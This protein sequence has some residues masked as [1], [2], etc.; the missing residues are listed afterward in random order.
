MA[1]RE[2]L[3][4]AVLLTLFWVTFGAALY[5]EY[6]PGPLSGQAQGYSDLVGALHGGFSLNFGLQKL[7]FAIGLALL[8]LG[9]V[10][11]PQRKRLGATLFSCA[12]L[13]LAVTVPLGDPQP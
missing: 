7:V 13:P 8:L 2:V 1:T 3:R 6:H 12:G 5:V 9:S 11:I 4:L 10:L